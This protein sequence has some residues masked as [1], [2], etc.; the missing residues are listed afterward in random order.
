MSGAGERLFVF[1]FGNSAKALNRLFA[2]RFASI[3][4]TT[5]SRERADALEELGIDAFVFD[6]TRPGRSVAD[7]LKSA[8]YVLSSV[9]PGEDGDPVLAH[10]A[11]DIAA[12]PGLRW[13]GY[14]S[15]IGVYG[16]HRGAVIDE[17]TPCRPASPRSRR[18][19]EAE[20][21]WTD[22]AE[23]IG[24]PAAIFRLAGIYGPGHNVMVRLMKGTA[25]RL[26]K[27]G[28]VFNRIHVDDI[29][30]IV[31]AA[32]AEDCGG[33][34]NVTDDEAAP[35]QDVVTFGAELMGVEPPPEEDFATAELSPM[36]RSFYGESKIVSNDRAKSVLGWKP[37]YPDYRSGLKRLW[38]TGDWDA[39]TTSER[40]R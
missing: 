4:G 9:P 24:V 22:L 39:E 32:I 15:T 26:V 36:A 3:A 40:K 1:G 2:D 30:S 37:R 8:T 35:P 25:R 5:R 12:A 21:A 23:E 34:F 14:L 17:E 28:Q 33:I 18:R 27:P 7:A 10:H 11:A 29:A 19:L 13:V 6:G 38:T 31:A 20:A 16:D